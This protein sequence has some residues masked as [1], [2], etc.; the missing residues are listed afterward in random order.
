[1]P[2][3][4][5]QQPHLLQRLRARHRFVGLTDGADQHEILFEQGKFLKCRFRDRQS[6]DGRIQF[7]IEQIRNQCFRD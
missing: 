3:F 4:Q 6:N 1:M 2:F 5:K 7:R